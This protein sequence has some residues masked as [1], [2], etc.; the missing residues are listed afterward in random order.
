MGAQRSEIGN[1][2]LKRKLIAEEFDAVS[3]QGELWDRSSFNYTR[4]TGK[5]AQFR[6]CAEG[7]NQS[8]LVDNSFYYKRRSSLRRYRVFH[9]A[10]HLRFTDKGLQEVTNIEPTKKVNSQECVTEK[11]TSIN[12]KEKRDKKNNIKLTTINVRTLVELKLNYKGKSKRPVD[13]LPFLIKEFH[14]YNS[15][16]MACQEVRWLNHGMGERDK[17]TYFYSGHKNTAREGVAIFIKSDL[18]IDSEYEVDYVS[19]RIV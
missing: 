11:E 15:S 4:R 13:K 18:L 1:Y 12:E 19:S 16:I 7:K 2:F 5:P 6:S 14:H 9:Q 17:V 3:F 10:L 8:L